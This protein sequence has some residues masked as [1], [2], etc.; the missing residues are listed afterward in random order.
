MTRYA[1]MR[2]TSGSPEFDDEQDAVA[3]AKAQ[4]DKSG[5][6][7]WVVKLVGKAQPPVLHPKYERLDEDETYPHARLDEDETYGDDDDN[8]E[9]LPLGLI[10]TEVSGDMVTQRFRSNDNEFFSYTFKATKEDSK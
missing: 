10:G 1:C 8:E 5:L 9:V 6:T 3:H 7:I 2:Q 4:A